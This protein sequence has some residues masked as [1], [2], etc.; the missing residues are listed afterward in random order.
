MD[1]DREIIEVIRGLART[2]GK[3]ISVTT[4]YKNITAKGIYTSNTGIKNALR[5]LETR[6]LIKSTTMDK[7]E[8][9]EGSDKK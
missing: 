1:K 7:I 9:L 2:G 8:L 4:V 5:R 6:G 3:T